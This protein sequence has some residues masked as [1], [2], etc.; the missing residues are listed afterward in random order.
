M[1]QFLAVYHIP[2]LNKKKLYTSL[3][4]N[5]IAYIFIYFYKKSI[6]MFPMNFTKRFFVNVIE[7]SWRVKHLL[8]ETVELFIGSK[9]KTLLLVWN[10]WATSE[11]LGHCYSEPDSQYSQLSYTL[12]ELLVFFLFF[13]RG[14][15]FNNFLK[16]M[17]PQ[18]KCSL[19]KYFL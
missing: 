10:L 15:K 18:V 3:Q 12:S 16:I 1:K 8:S 2:K 7:N 14:K 19:K 6:K 13:S 9:S 17:F 4:E 11:F 5:V